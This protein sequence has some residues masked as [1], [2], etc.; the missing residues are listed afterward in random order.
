MRNQIIVRGQV[1]FERDAPTFVDA[2]IRVR[3][4]DVTQ[5]D[6]PA[7]VVAEQVIP[8]VSYVGRSEASVSFALESVERL[9]ERARYNLRVHVDIDGTGRVT[10]GDFITTESYPIHPGARPVELTV[11]VRRVR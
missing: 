8:G 5:A 1:R 6:A 4:E 3:L 10:P 11:F 7:Q 9:D 2:T